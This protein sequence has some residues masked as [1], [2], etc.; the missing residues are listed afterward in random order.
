MAF[1]ATVAAALAPGRL[2]RL[3]AVTGAVTLA[4]AD[5]AHDDS[6]LLFLLFLWALP[7]TMT[8]LIT[9]AALGYHAVHRPSSFCEALQVLFLGRWPAL[10]KLRTTWP[11]A[12]LDADDV[13]LVLMPLEI[14]NGV[15]IRD[16]LVLPNEVGVH[17]CLTEDALEL[18][19]SHFRVCLD[20]GENGL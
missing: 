14:D 15:G 1:L 3:G 13:L 2:S 5:S 16:L 12:E 8:H 11:V 6:L 18:L 17:G 20:V 7:A 19:K 10:R 4:V 9:V